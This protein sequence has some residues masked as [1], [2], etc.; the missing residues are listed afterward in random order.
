METIEIPVNSIAIDHRDLG[1]CQFFLVIFLIDPGTVKK[2]LFHF[3][4]DQFQDFQ[5]FITIIMSILH[6]LC[7]DPYS[8]VTVF[9]VSSDGSLCA[10][11][12]TTG[13]VQVFDVQNT[14]VKY[15]FQG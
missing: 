2:K 4:I 5:S 8:P 14:K 13:S 7:L 10:S 6:L 1:W 12:D 9:A 3:T 11:A 15:L